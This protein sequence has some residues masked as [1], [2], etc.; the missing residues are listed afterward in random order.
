MS[1]LTSKARRPSDEYAGLRIQLRAG[2]CADEAGGWPS[3]KD[4]PAPPKPTARAVTT[5]A[6]PII[7]NLSVVVLMLGI[8]AAAF[9]F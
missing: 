1:P 8:F 6:L 5:I 9:L 7:T 3:G 2:S 4:Q